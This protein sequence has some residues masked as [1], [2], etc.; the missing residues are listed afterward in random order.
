MGEQVAAAVGK[1]WLDGVSA[2]LEEIDYACRAALVPACAVNAP[3]RRGRLWFAAHTD[4]P[5]LEGQPG[6]VV[7]AARMEAS[8]LDLL[9]QQV[10]WIAQN[11]PT[12]QWPTPMASLAHK[13]VRSTE[14]AIR[15]EARN[16]GPDLAAVT[17]AAVALCPTPRASAN[18]NRTTKIPPSQLDGRHGL[19][20]S[21]VAIG[22]EPAGSS[23][24]TANTG[25]LNPAFVCWLMGFP[26]E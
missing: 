22:M 1:N 12:A 17:A 3:H 10:Y 2:D 23:A 19:Y 24:T 11:S 6:H 18:E 25:A 15:E 21:S 7:R 16:H 20:L 13:G 14:G 4:N 9:P 8:R 5:G 26:A